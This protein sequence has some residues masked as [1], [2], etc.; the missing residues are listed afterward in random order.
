MLKICF[1]SL[2]W[3]LRSILFKLC[4]LVDIE[5]KWFGIV[6]GYKSYCPLCMLNIG[7]CAQS[8]AFLAD[9]LQTMY[10]S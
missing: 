5:E 8:W 1:R 2:S 9:S 3:E 4:I 7:F 6:D 10:T